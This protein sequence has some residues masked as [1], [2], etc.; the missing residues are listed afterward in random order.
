MC[1]HGRIYLFLELEKQPL[2]SVQLNRIRL[3]GPS[4][5]SGKSTFPLLLNT[6]HHQLRLLTRFPLLSLTHPFSHPLS[7]LARWSEKCAWIV[8]QGI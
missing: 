5:P 3:R 2:L 1:F 4:A 7:L 6:F 8:H